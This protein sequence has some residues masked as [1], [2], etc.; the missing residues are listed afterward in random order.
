MVD[1]STLLS[2][3]KAIVAARLDW[4]QEPRAE[5]KLSHSIEDF[6]V[7]LGPRHSY[8]MIW[9]RSARKRVNDVDRHSQRDL[10]E[11]LERSWAFHLL[12]SL[13]GRKVRVKFT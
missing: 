2:Y 4:K 13:K 8:L 1:R 9:M 12:D 5:A 6:N 10:R 11:E 3:C 7:C